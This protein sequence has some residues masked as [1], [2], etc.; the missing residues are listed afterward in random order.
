MARTA[1]MNEMY[2]Y[3]NTVPKY[4][5]NEDDV[6]DYQR[7]AKERARRAYEEERLRA[8]RRQRRILEREKK[9]SRTNMVVMTM[10]SVVILL[11]CAVYIHL[12]AQLMTTMA[13]V[14][15]L[16]TEVINLTAEN[17][18][19]EKNIETS[20]DL[21]KIRKTAEKELGMVYP[22]ESQI[23]YYHVDNADYM[24]QYKEIPG[25]TSGNVLDKIFIK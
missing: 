8:R 21:E 25:K 10:A 11:L 20:V 7:E 1:R 2:V 6:F 17:D 24:E 23:E 18:S 15:N 5:P 3:G 19:M 16:K 12:N 4:I 14:S 9:I 22:K 13:N